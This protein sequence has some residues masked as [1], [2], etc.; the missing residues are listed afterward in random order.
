MR[1]STRK[2]AAFNIIFSDVKSTRPARSTKAC[3]SASRKSTSPAASASTMCSSSTRRSCPAAPSYPIRSTFLRNALIAGLL[4]GVGLAYLLERLDDVVHSSDEAER[5]SGLTDAR[6]HPE[7]EKPRNRD[8][9]PAV[10]PFRSLPFAVHDAATFDSGRACRR[11][12]LS[13]ARCRA[14]ANPFPAS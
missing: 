1:R 2:N 4:A 11:R 13:R 14:K 3:C 6:H 5:L 12:C 8:G 7:S 9:G 10:G